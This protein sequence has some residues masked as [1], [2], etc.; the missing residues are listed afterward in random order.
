MQASKCV[1]F[2]RV[3]E[4][5]IKVGPLQESPCWLSWIRIR[6]Y[7]SCLGVSFYLNHGYVQYA[8]RSRVKHATN[9]VLAGDTVVSGLY[10]YLAVFEVRGF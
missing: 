7:S 3:V 9:E 8:H 4:S 1:S 6:D 2:G 10:V 5:Y